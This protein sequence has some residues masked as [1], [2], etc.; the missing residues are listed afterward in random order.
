MYRICSPLTGRFVVVLC[1]SAAIATAY[2]PFVAQS[3]SGASG[4]R[5]Q[6]NTTGT[7]APTHEGDV[8]PDQRANDDQPEPIDAARRAPPLPE[9][10][11]GNGITYQGELRDANGPVVGSTDL[12]FRL[13]DAVTGGAQIGPMLQLLGA[14]LVDGR[15]TVELDFG[16][17]AF[18]AEARW[19][20]IDVFD[21]GAGSFVTLSPRQPVTAAPVALFALDGNQGPQGPIGPE[22]PQGPQGL[23][24]PQGLQGDPGVQGPEGPIGRTGPQGLPGPIG[25]EGPQGT[26]GLTGPQGPIGPEGP[27]GQQGLPGDSHWLINGSATYYNAGNV[28]IGTPTPTARLDVAQGDIVATDAGVTQVQISGVGPGGELSMRNDNGTETLEI[29]G[30]AASAGATLTTFDVGTGAITVS[31][32]GD[33]SRGG[34]I[35]TR[36]EDGFTQST[37][38]PDVSAG[39][40]VFINWRRTDSSTGFTFDGNASSSGN[41]R[42]TLSSGVSPMTFDTN[43][44]GS[45]SVVLPTDAIQASEILDEAGAASTSTNTGLALTGA[46]DTILSRTITV[47]ADGYVLAIATCQANASHVSGT[48][49]WAEFGVSD[50]AGVIP[51]TQD[52]AW[53]IPSAHP[54]GP[55]NRPVTVQAIFSVVSGAYSFYFLGNE[56]G[57]NVTCNDMTL[58]LIYVPTAYGMVD[59][60]LGGP[61]SGDNMAP[62]NAPLSAVD[63]EA[64]QIEAEEFNQQRLQRELQQMQ[65]QMQ[66]LQA[67]LDQVMREQGL[68]QPV[69]RAPHQE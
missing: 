41:P 51:A 38:E 36:S 1:A 49:S 3:E 20:E 10:P 12:Q 68:E 53:L 30:G 23:T 8:P 67:Q 25:P 56:N 37:I 31:V 39:G 45:A 4:A 55:I 29:L 65:A 57:G 19:L 42:M 6:I 13:F 50:T 69:P 33:T 62:E 59:L 66:A 15:F 48:T 60:P 27:Q 34:R 9:D 26:Q 35:D 2:T 24:G 58:S 17:G 5:Q 63:I 46:V 44:S 32:V 43:A 64:E 52:V 61:G 54:S 21:S 11:V 14:P 18:T 28:G 7:R 16:P 47:P 40:G 22:G